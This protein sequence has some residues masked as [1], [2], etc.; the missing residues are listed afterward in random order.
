MP[1]ARRFFPAFFAR[2]SKADH[3]SRPLKSAFCSGGIRSARSCCLFG[4]AGS[5]KTT[6]LIRYAVASA[7]RGA[8]VLYICPGK[9]GFESSR[10]V[11]LV[12]KDSPAAAAALARVSIR[13]LP[14]AEDLRMYM[15]SVHMQSGPDAAAFR[16]LGGSATLRR[17]ATDRNDADGDLSSD[18]PSDPPSGSPSD[19]QRDVAPDVIIVDAIDAYCA[20]RPENAPAPERLIRTLALLADAAAAGGKTLLLAC[21]TE[22]AAAGTV[23]G[24]IE[25]SADL[26]AVGAGKGAGRSPASTMELTTTPASAAEGT[27]RL[28]L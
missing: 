24:W 5:G 23:R 28:A 16:W 2:E 6:L 19:P 15:A 8:R 11:N 20:A 10:A 4:P 17:P 3:P 12:A 13:Y 21:G 9:R 18:P 14:T 22:G 7:R 26:C 1:A 27:A 25:V